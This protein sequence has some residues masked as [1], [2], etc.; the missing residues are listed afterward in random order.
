MS[1]YVW[2]STAIGSAT[3]L[4]PF[5]HDR[6]TETGEGEEAC[7]KVVEAIEAGERVR[8]DALPTKAWLTANAGPSD[9]KL[10]HFFKAYSIPI[11][12]DDAAAVLRQFDLGGGG[13]YPIEV[14]ERDQ[15]TPIPGP[16]HSIAFGNTKDAFVP[17]ESPKARKTYIR[18][19]G[20]EGWT[21]R[22]TMKD[23]DMVVTTSALSG[24][25]IW[26]DERVGDA[27]FLSAALG[28]ALKKAKAD[29][30]WMLKKVKV[31]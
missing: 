7:I 13:L 23:G 6:S 25:D 4:R 9:S 20:V 30:G 17:E 26:I 3:N 8:A 19:G 10:P 15:K 21:P 12:H 28:S 29:K 31:C 1:E 22:S 5:R 2:I 16:W 27:V 24:P 11:V 18:P 14:F